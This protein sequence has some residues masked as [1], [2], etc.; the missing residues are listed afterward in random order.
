MLFIPELLPGIH[1]SKASRIPQH[2]APGVAPMGSLSR[3]PRSSY[4]AVWGILWL[5]AVRGEPEE[6][7]ELR[8]GKEGEK[9]GK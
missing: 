7:I 1:E 5:V 2:E 9:N 8:M 4:R 6:G 3:T